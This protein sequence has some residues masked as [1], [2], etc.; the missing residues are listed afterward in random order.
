M[1]WSHTDN[2]CNIFGVPAHENG[3]TNR[4]VGR[5]KLIGDHTR[6]DIIKKDLKEVDKASKW[7][8]KFSLYMSNVIYVVHFNVGHAAFRKFEIRCM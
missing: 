5:Y 2:H 7:V 6:L 4:P 1:T 3:L 8:Q